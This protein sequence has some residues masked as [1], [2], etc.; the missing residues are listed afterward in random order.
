MYTN[1]NNIVQYR[2]TAPSYNPFL[3]PHLLCLFL[4]TLTLILST[5]GPNTPFLP[6]LTRDT[7]SVL[8]SLYTRP[9][10]DDPSIL[11][12]LLSLYLIIVDLN[13]ASGTTGE[14]RLVTDLATQVL[15]LRDWAGEVFDRT[16][17][18]QGEN[19]PQNQVRTLAAGVMVKLGEVVERYQGRLMGVNSGFK[20]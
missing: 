18:V 14:E 16:P 4:Q 20:F 10:A 15:E 7:L 8:L 11:S 9:L 19:E 1:T 5:T 12:A 17:A 13:I 6:G 2:S 3:I